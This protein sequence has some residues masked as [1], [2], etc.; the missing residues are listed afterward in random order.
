MM[1]PESSSPVSFSASDSKKTLD[2]VRRFW[3]DNPLFT[4]ESSYQPGTIEFFED[5]R[6]VYY[7]DCFPG[8]LDP[9]LFP[10]NC[11]DQRVLDVGCGTGFWIV[12]FWQ[13]GFRNITGCDLSENSLNIA[14]ERAKLYEVSADFYVENAESLSFADGEFTHVNCQGVIHHTPHPEKALDEIHRVLS[15]NGTATI[16][17]YYKNIILRRWRYFYPFA[18]ILYVLGAKLKG[19]G[20]DGLYQLLSTEEIVRQYDGDKNP[21]GL[22]FTT[23][24][25]LA[26]LEKKF[27]VKNVYFHFFPVRS[28]P[29]YVPRWI[30]RFLDGRLPFMIYANVVKKEE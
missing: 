23:E 10:E 28:L 22:S 17:V 24:H 3:N 30:H 1:P 14:K 11:N 25:F 18:R 6:H 21:I 15:K 19:R 7:N 9:Q 8:E 27:D 12:E 13:R 2:D 29:F 26:F 20:R 4:G 5:H 16:S